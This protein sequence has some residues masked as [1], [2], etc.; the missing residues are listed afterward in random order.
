[1]IIRN[2]QDSINVAHRLQLEWVGVGPVN[3]QRIQ[4]SIRQEIAWTEANPA[5]MTPACLTSCRNDLQLVGQL[6]NRFADV[7]VPAG[8]QL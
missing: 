6:R 8:S 1:M 7:F 4:A 3:L 5:R 2:W